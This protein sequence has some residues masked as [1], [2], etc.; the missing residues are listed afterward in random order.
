M[1]KHRLAMAVT[2]ALSAC[3]GSPAEPASH[4]AGP[5][6]PID[7]NVPCVANPHTHLEIINACTDA[8]AIDKDVDLSSMDLPDGGLRPLP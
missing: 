4:D 3:N 6:V 2:L 8:Q 7:A 1:A 5:E